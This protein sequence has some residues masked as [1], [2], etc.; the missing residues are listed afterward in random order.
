MLISLVLFYFGL[1]F[2]PNSNKLIIM[3]IMINIKII[4]KYPLKLLISRK[5]KL[6][7]MNI[8]NKVKFV[9]EL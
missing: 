8:D 9:H 3:I 2:K 4:D 1:F 6:F 5:F 7:E